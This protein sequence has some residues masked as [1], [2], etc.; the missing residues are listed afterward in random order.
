MRACVRCSQKKRTAQPC[1][2]SAPNATGERAGAGSGYPFVSDA[3]RRTQIQGGFY[4]MGV[5]WMAKDVMGTEGRS[6]VF[7]WLESMD[8][9]V[10]VAECPGGGLVKGRWGEVC[11]Q[12]LV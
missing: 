2:R 4:R 9:G 1:R 8:E 11:G 12:S 5:G 6:D 7:G 3:A 10:V